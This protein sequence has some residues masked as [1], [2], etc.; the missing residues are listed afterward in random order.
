MKLQYEND[1]RK[2]VIAF[3]LASNM[4]ME[5]DSFKKYSNELVKLK[6]QYEE[7][8][9]CLEKQ[10]IIPK[11]GSTPCSWTLNFSTCEISLIY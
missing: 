7:A 2:D 9:S 5:T 10:Y 4:N 11:I 6:V 3:M 1:S 8:K